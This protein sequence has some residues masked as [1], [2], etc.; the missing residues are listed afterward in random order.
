MLYVNNVGTVPGK[1]GLLMRPAN[2]R[3]AAKRR[4]TV[5]P[6]H[7]GV[8]YDAPLHLYEDPSGYRGKIARGESMLFI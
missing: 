2:H 7:V 4:H 8:R 1:K 5:D 3:K 6:V